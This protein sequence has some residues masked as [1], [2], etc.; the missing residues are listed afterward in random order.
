MARVNQALETGYK[1][2]IQ[3]T[4]NFLANINTR[5]LSSRVNNPVGKV[6][7][8]IAETPYTF[9]TSVP[10]T[11]GQTVNE[12][13]S[14]GIFTKEGQQRTAGRFVNS[15][16]DTASGGL[17]N[18]ARGLVSAAGPAVASRAGGALKDL[19][20]KGAKTGLK[21]GA[22]YGAGYGFGSSMEQNKT[23]QQIALEM[24]KQ[25]ALGG[26]MG[27]ALGGAIPAASGLIKAV[28]HDIN[29]ARGKSYGK[30]DFLPD[31][32]LS[33]LEEINGRMFPGE[34]FRGQTFDPN[35]PQFGR[36]A[37]EVGEAL[38]RPGMSIK[39]VS[40]DLPPQF[41][42]KTKP[43]M[44]EPSINDFPLL[45]ERTKIAG[46]NDQRPSAIGGAREK[47]RGFAA[48]V[49]EAP[50]IP[51]QMKPGEK[52][53]YVPKKDAQLM[54]EAK[55]LLED[56][57]SIDLKTVQNGDAKVVATMQYAINEG[58]KGNMDAGA[59]VLNN[60]YDLGTEGGRLIRSF[61]LLK[62]LHP[63]SIALSVVG[64]IKR[65]NS[66]HPDSPI[67][68]MDG[69]QF[70]A[71]GDMA[72]KIVD[73]PDG[74]EKNIAINDMQ[75]AIDNLIP[76]TIADKVMTV[77][78]AGLLTSLRTT[79]RNLL[80][81]TIQAGSEIVKDA[82]AVGMDALL[83]MK[84]GK[85]TVS[86]T[87]RGTIAG[88]KGSLQQMKDVF[89]HG[90]DP[91]ET[92]SKFDVRRTTW[93]NNKV[94][95]GLKWYTE[96]V[97]RILGVQDIPFFNSAYARSLYSQAGA[98]AINAGQKGTKAKPFIEN[99]VKNPTEE[100]KLLATQDAS[101]ATFKDK[102]KAGEI[103]SMIKSEARKAPGLW[104][105][106]GTVVTEA[107]IPFTSVPT[108]IAGKMLDYSPIGLGKSF[109]RAG[110]V[111]NGKVNYQ[112]EAAQAFGR[113]AVGTA[114]L[115][116]GAELMKN[117]LMTGY[118]KSPEEARQWELEGKTPRSVYFM[119]KWRSISSV[120]PQTI[121]LLAGGAM[122]DAKSF[123]E[124]ALT[125]GK[126]FFNQTVL[127]GVQRPMQALVDPSRY[128][129]S[130]VQGLVGSTVPNIVKDS[131]SSADL[132]KREINS[133]GEAF[134]SGIPFARNQL[135]P[136]RGVLGEPVKNEGYGIGAFVDIFN[137]RTPIHTPAIDE[138]SRLNIVDMGATPGKIR[139]TETIFGKKVTFTPEELD[140]LEEASGNALRPALENLVT[141]PGYAQMS[142]ENKQE[143]IGNLVKDIRS[144]AKTS[145]AIGSSGAGSA[146]QSGSTG[147]FSGLDTNSV[148]KKY[149]EQIFKQQFEASD[150]IKAEFG[151]KVWRKDEFGVAR[152]ISKSSYDSQLYTAK[153]DAAE[154]RDDFKGW[155]E[156]ATKQYN[157][158]N[159]RLNDP[160]LDE[161]E[162]EK[163]Q[164]QIRTLVTKAAKFKRYG[165]FT[166]PKAPRKRKA[167]KFKTSLASLKKTQ[168]TKRKAPTLY[169]Q[170]KASANTKP[171]F[172]VGSGFKVK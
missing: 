161:L 105:Q 80:G 39:D 135:L 98:A 159:E 168:T 8:G 65:Y 36:A 24:L 93:G 19:V 57:A 44:P 112:R 54:G 12:I 5:P 23:P 21:T 129:E 160:T 134:Q 150:Q 17:L 114:V 13:Q 146:G 167:I 20:I 81:N 152:P 104:G 25:G 9:L 11:Y 59:A 119:G 145:M 131:S 10:K 89:T 158:L 40:G 79:G 72:K 107:V 82:P 154:D 149:Q 68:E 83:A 18:K 37:R 118:P 84:T 153:L 139:E 63:E 35:A 95:Q 61:G 127:G 45:S 50:N 125:I 77:W 111:L 2:V 109:Y 136:K 16:L 121:L 47:I 106:I 128:G 94:E 156:L 113:G 96:K 51:E 78:K 170:P 66:T 7:A 101:Y 148:E 43:I 69:A 87:T 33:G 102:G 116:A 15:A 62:K 164:N 56:G 28:K 130:Y 64:K 55:A 46:L 99:L 1:K 86:M 115:A 6:V 48:S 32:I 162:L 71:F 143:M 133:V 138:L 27:G 26:V 147:G 169:K 60:L 76:S 22:G 3:P 132:Y 151:G 142:D 91:E 144:R 49:N 110:Q 85:R 157:T 75:Q 97:F 29:V 123:G 53:T 166:K 172:S 103:L 73:M 108:S 31:R 122:Q 88:T 41:S 34:R 38:P 70:K 137:S 58:A 52:F 171:F 30:P 74:R 42:P 67:P 14:G 124:G 117:G 155:F 120:G 126:D 165:G 92:I 100:M 140:K 90:Y 163:V 4:N 141:S